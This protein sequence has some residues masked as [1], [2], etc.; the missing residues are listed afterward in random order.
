MA[1]Y[2]VCTECDF[3]RVLGERATDVSLPEVCPACGSELIVQYGE[4]RF[5][6]TYVSRVRRSLQD[7]TLET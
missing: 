4:A 7:A 3:L 6:P 1:N 2:A 5:Q